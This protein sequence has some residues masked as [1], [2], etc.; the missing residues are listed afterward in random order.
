TAQNT[1]E[2]SRFEALSEEM[3]SAQIETLSRDLAPQAVKTGM[4]ASEG[5]IKEVSEHL[6]SFDC[7]VICDPVLV[8]GSGDALGSQ[9]TTEALKKYMFRVAELIT[10]N[11][12]EASALVGRKISNPEE[13]ERAGLEL[14]ETGVRSVL[15]KGGHDSGKWVQNFYCDA[16][17]KFW[18]TYPR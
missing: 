11:L 10:P 17:Q 3:V 1:K 12:P 2:V 8:S 4:M 9:G 15:I 16:S 5:L 18:L 13:I 14:L 7:P 6:K